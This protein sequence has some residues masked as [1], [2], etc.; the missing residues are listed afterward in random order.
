MDK[1]TLQEIKNKLPKHY[2][3]II[4][5]RTELSYSTIYKTFTTERQ[6]KQVIIAALE[7]I[8]ENLQFNNEIKERVK[9]VCR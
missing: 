1:S 9:K 5:E 2:A 7:L 4:K 3:S 8:E 6:N